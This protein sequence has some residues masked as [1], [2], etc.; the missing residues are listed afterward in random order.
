MSPPRVETV[1]VL[2]HSLVFP[3]TTMNNHNIS[4]AKGC[5]V[6]TSWGRQG[7][8]GD[9]LRPPRCLCTDGQEVDTVTEDS[10]IM[11][12]NKSSES[13][14]CPIE[15]HSGAMRYAERSVPRL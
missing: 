6:A 3:H 7:S 9:H 15:G 1:T 12:L 11:T 2:Q 14:E 4:L 8:C 10:D 13:Q 5:R